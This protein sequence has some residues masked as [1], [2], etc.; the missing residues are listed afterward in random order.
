MRQ[1]TP[2]PPRG[3]HL[4]SAYEVAELIG[5]SPR[6]V[7]ALPIRQIRIGA[8]TI[9]YRLRDVYD[10]FGLDDHPNDGD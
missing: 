1:S 7:L 5:T 3:E 9:R 8:R 2:Q 10:Y 6:L 4:L